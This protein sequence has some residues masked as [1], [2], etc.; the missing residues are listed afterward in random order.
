[1]HLAFFTPEFYIP[2]SRRRITV[3]GTLAAMWRNTRCF[4]QEQAAPFG[5]WNALLSYDG[6]FPRPSSHQTKFTFP[7]MPS[8]YYFFILPFEKENENKKS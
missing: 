2:A 6:R 8:K 4:I 1:M 5:I 7:S 3:M